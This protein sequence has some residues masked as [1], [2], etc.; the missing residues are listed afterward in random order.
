MACLKVAYANVIIFLIKKMSL[1]IEI[2]EPIQQLNNIRALVKLLQES[3]DF[4][5]WSK[6]TIVFPNI[7]RVS[8]KPRW[9]G[10]D[11]F[12]FIFLFYYIW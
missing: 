8:L 4:L 12:I 3:P 9:K 6:K 10:S 5:S 2:S 11:S 1:D 7:T